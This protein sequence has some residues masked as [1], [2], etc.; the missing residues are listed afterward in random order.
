MNKMLSLAKIMF[1]GLAIYLCIGIARNILFTIAV[2]LQPFSWQ[3]LGIFIFSLCLSLAFLTAVIKMLI[4]KRD[5]WARKLIA[6]DIAPDQPLSTELTLFMTF[7]LVCVGIGLYCLR[8]F[9]WSIS[10]L[11]RNLSMNIK[12]NLDPGEVRYF[13]T[14]GVDYIQPVLL[15]ALAVYLL[16]GAPHFVRWQVKKTLELCNEPGDDI[17]NK[18]VE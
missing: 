12:Y 11:L 13:S 4:F 16:C 18:P 6:K 5:K 7:R 8:S 1:V 15:L 9:L 17:K 2:I 3:S 14:V 10:S